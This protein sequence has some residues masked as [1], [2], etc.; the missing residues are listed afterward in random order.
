MAEPETTYVVLLGAV[1]SGKSTIV[2]KVTGKTQKAERSG[3]SATKASE[4]FWTQ[5]GEFVISDTPG[6][7]GLGDR[8]NHNIWIA[9]AFN[10]RPVSKIFI[11]AKATLG[12]M[13]SVIEGIREYSDRFVNLPNAPLG[14][15][16]THMD[17]I[18]QWTHQKMAMSLTS[19]QQLKKKLT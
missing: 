11:V 14:V 7:N 4:A 6:S 15:I 19:R 9:A 12:R 13:D 3:R 8:F 1:G 5:Q 2:R 16:L 17:K 18:D 10:F